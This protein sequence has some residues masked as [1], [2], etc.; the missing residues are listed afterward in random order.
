[1]HSLD[2]M[3]T[4]FRFIG[5]YICCSH[6]YYLFLVWKSAQKCFKVEVIYDIL[7]GI[8]TFKFKRFSSYVKIEGGKY[9]K[10]VGVIDFDIL[11]TIANDKEII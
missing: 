6:T 4:I 1:M 7:K 8:T 10:S 2:I 9:A 5:T 3:L 11:K